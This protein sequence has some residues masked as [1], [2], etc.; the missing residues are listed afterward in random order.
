MMDFNERV[1]PGVSSNFMFKEALARY[2]FASKF[3]SAKDNVL[4]FGCGT[5]YGSFYLT[6]LSAHVTGVDIDRE[7]LAFAR[8]KYAKK[9][10]NFKHGNVE[11]KINE[12]YNAICSFEVVEHINSP[13]AYLENI[14]K[15]LLPGGY[16]ILSTPNSKVSS[17][18]GKLQSEYHTKEYDFNELSSMLNRRFKSV[19]IYG[20]TKS[21]KAKAAWKDFLVS[22][23]KRQAIVTTDKLGIR[24]LIPKSVKEKAWKI[25]G[26]FAGR[27]PQEYLDTADFPVTLKNVK[28]ADYFIA[29]CQKS[30]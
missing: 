2:E 30:Q 15:S 7:A 26:N 16:F 19:K 6:K 23:D 11:N 10:L 27:K 3:I 9:G 24:K 8:K 29:V 18:D 21:A 20:Q 1:I 25:I 13:K 22:Q 5:G 4:D 12:K 17:P 14:Y 28:M